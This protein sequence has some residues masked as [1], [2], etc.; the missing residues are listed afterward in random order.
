MKSV[1]MALFV[2]LFVSCSSDDLVSSKDYTA[3]N[4]QEILS[5]ISA[6]NLDAVATGSGLYYVID[7]QGDGAAITSTSDVT[8]KY[9]GRYTDGTIFDSSEDE[10]I[11]FYLQYVIEGWQEGLPYFNE[12]GV[13]QL[14][15]PSHLAY[16]SSDYNS[17]PG[18]SVLVFDIEIIDYAA[19]N[20]AEILNY[21]ADNDLDA[22]ST[23]SGLYYVIDEQGTGAQPTETSYVTV[24]YKGYYSDGEVFEENSDGSSFYLDNV[25]EGW[26]EGLSYFNEGGSGTLLI[27]SDL[28]YGRYGSGTIPG[29]AVL[30]FDIELV[31]VN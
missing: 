6:Y 10:A 23:D 20:E 13:G 31:A 25:I 12:G 21:I 7:E 22:Q 1:C 28:A 4:E 30:I 26:Q 14:I 29:G 18:G 17:I 16:G 9:V 27:P 8:V 3:E 24:N 19:E 15:I 11:S 2:V 5:Y